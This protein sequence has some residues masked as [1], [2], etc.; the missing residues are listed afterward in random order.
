MDHHLIHHHRWT[1]LGGRRLEREWQRSSYSTQVQFCPAQMSADSGSVCGCVP[2]ELW[3]EI[4]GYASR[5]TLKQ[6]HVTQR[7]FHRLSRPLLFRDFDFQPYAIDHY[8]FGANDVILPAAAELDRAL[9]RLKF[10][11]SAEIAPHA[12]FARAGSTHGI[13][14]R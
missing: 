1:E 12:V 2:E 8:G 10:W 14:R 11:T 9:Q 13:W 6:L 3:T 4:V 5:E 7:R